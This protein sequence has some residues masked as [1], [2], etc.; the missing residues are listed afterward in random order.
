MRLLIDATN[1]R[2]GGGL[3]H[4]KEIIRYLPISDNEKIFL[5]ADKFVCDKVVDRSLLIKISP[6][7]LNRSPIIRHLW[8]LL[9]LNSLVRKNNID[10]V[11]SPGGGTTIQGLPIVTMCR[12]MLPFD[13]NEALRFGFSL[14]TLKLIALHF[15]QLK[16][17]R[18]ASGLIFL[19]DYAKNIVMNFIGKNLITEVIPHGI[20]DSFH[21][22]NRDIEKSGKL[23]NEEIRFVYVSKFDPYKNHLTVISGLQSLAKSRPSH[24]FILNLIGPKGHSY[25]KVLNKVRSNNISNLSIYMYEEM[26]HSEIADFYFK[27]DIGIFASSCENMPNILLEMMSAGMVIVCA[28]S[29]SMSDILGEGGVYFSPY[30]YKSLHN[31]L[32]SILNDQTLAITVKTKAIEKSKYYSWQTSASNTLNFIRAIYK[33]NNNGN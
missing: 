1:I 5:I 9:F 26:S 33:L 28:N 18:Q 32:E 17:F 3:T 21:A 4:L 6:R 24:S 7:S 14:M 10:I 2:Q 11:F 29:C 25:K 8:R 27:S 31:A 30:D 20:S 12:N 19:T 16:S 22:K 13:H 15:I 23:I